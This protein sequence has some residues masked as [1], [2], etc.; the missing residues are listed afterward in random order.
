M[1]RSPE[2][3][4]H[5]F[6]VEK[7]LAARL[8]V[9][10]RSE[11][12]TLVPEL[13]GELYR[14]VPDHPRSK[15]SAKALE[16]TSFY[17][18]RMNLVQSFLGAEID[19]VEFG[20]GDGGFT[21]QVLSLVRSAVSLEVC[22]QVGE[23]GIQNAGPKW[24]Y[25]DG[26][27]VPLPDQS[28]DVAFSYQ[29][30]EHVHPDDV[31]LHLQEAARILKPRGVY[32]LSTPHLFSGP[33]DISRHFTDQ[34]ETFHMKEWTYAELAKEMKKA[35]FLKIGAYV[36]GRHRGRIGFM[37]WHLA[38]FI[39]SLSPSGFRKTLARRFLNN[40]VISGTLP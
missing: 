35:G 8:R 33:H 7:E 37:F 30:L 13:Y 28:Y 32:V 29:V 20:A 31:P 3:F 16:E 2:A 12:A 6:A 4:R 25:Y 21:R 5:H 27:T 24:I 38:E 36:K 1:S 40:V 9:R 15:Q 23:E 39:M 34:L 17:Q 26:L 14:R 22:E 10:E 11:R 19:F 18:S